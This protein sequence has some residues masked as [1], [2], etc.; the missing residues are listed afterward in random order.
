MESKIWEQEDRDLR[1]KEIL[2]NLA[3]DLRKIPKSRKDDY[4]KKNLRE[5]INE[6][7]VI[8]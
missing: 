8:D 7:K 1:I 2:D 6:K 5:F 3:E 4:I